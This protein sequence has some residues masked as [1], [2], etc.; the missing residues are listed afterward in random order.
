MKGKKWL[1][2]GKSGKKMSTNKARPTN[3]ITTEV[4]KRGF[5]QVKTNENGS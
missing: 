5:P 4:S 2:I 1:L 3:E